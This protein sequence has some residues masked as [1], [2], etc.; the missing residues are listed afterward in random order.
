MYMYVWLHI[1]VN[2][3]LCWLIILILDYELSASVHACT[4]TCIST[5]G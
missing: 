4:C 2:E 3:N 5:T 1:V